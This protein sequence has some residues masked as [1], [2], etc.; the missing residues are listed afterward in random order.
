LSLAYKKCTA[1]RS[2]VPKPVLNIDKVKEAAELISA[3]TIYSMDKVS[4][5]SSGGRIKGITRK[6][7]IPAAWTILGLSALPTDHDLNVGMLGMHGI[8]GQM[9]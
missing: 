1:I 7:G 8:M 4:F 5:R 6:S 2:Y 3:K 9:F